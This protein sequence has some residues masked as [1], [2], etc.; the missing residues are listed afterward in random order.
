MVV[1]A[2][3]SLAWCFPDEQSDY[4][5]EVLERLR[6]LTMLVPSLWAVEVANGLVMGERRK[7]LRSAE[8]QRFLQLAQGLT[9]RQDVQPGIKNMGIC[10][11][12]AREYGLSA[13]DA[14][15]LELAIRED[16]VLA[17]LDTDLRKAA[18]RAGV[19]I[20]ARA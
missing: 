19:G 12:V 14:A 6:D 4:A 7:R 1:D 2:S 18:K 11:A 20:F 9:I 10:T 17:T 5:D 13:Y 3:V 8:I 15:Y 16:L